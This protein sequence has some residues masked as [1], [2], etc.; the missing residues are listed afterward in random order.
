[1]MIKMI[2]EVSIYEKICL[3]LSL[4]LMIHHNYEYSY[5]IDISKNLWYVE[6]DSLCCAP[7]YLKINTI[8][9]LLFFSS[10]FFFFLFFF[11]RLFFLFYWFLSSLNKNV[12]CVTVIDYTCINFFL[13]FII[14]Y[15]HWHPINLPS[16]QY[17]ISVRNFTFSFK[18]RTYDRDLF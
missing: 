2:V 6:R 8:L 4:W 12:I 17:K 14:K 15:F 7:T 5:K 10:G 13:W 3:S 1:M 18:Y 9:W 11:F 16:V